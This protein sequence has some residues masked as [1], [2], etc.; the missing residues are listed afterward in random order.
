MYWEFLYKTNQILQR[1]IVKEE[2]EGTWNWEAG[3]GKWIFNWIRGFDFMYLNVE[4]YNYYC[5]VDDLAVVL[6]LARNGFDWK[7]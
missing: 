4:K 5:W 3:E 6:V 7:N 1:Y 2:K